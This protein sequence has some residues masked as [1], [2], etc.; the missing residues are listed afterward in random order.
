MALRA[1]CETTIASHCEVRLPQVFVESHSHRRDPQLMAG[2]GYKPSVNRI[3][4]LV[5][6]EAKYLGSIAHSA[7]KIGSERLD[8]WRP[9]RSIWRE[10]SSALGL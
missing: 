8:Q 9:R 1:A 4:I 6:D 7:C 10:T 2:E 3:S 5:E